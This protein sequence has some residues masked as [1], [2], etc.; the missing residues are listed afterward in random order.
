LHDKEL[1]WC[2]MRQASMQLP[3]TLAAITA[4]SFLLTTLQQL[5]HLPRC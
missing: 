2:A 4:T 3:H 5:P 1:F